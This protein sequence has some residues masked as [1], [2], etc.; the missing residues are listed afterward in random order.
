[1]KRKIILAGCAAAIAV[2]AAVNVGISSNNGYLSDLALANIEA[3]AKGEDP[4]GIGKCDTQKTMYVAECL[5][6]FEYEC[7]SGNN[8]TCLEGISAWNHCTSENIYN[9]VGGG[10]C[11]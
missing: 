11:Q 5:T 3:L 6:V 8:I 4:W 1:M 10:S 9:N 2:G 7:T